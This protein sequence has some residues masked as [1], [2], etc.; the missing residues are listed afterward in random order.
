MRAVIKHCKRCGVVI[1]ERIHG[2][3]YCNPCAVL[4]EKA[5]DQ[6]QRDKVFDTWHSFKIEQGC[7]ICGYNRNSAAL[8]H[9]HIGG[10]DGAIT[11]ADWYRG[12]T[13][14]LKKCV[15]VC[16]NCHTEIHFSNRGV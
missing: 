1:E 10:K 13:E 4:S 5:S 14:E 12:R 3:Q 2:Q 9:H 15:L 7:S 11:A 6:Q 8:E 16:R